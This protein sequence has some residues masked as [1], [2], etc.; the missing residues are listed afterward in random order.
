MRVKNAVVYNGNNGGGAV[1]PSAGH[2][3]PP[4]QH[5]GNNPPPSDYVVVDAVLVIGEGVGGAAVGV[6]ERKHPRITGGE[7]APQTPT[8]LEG[9]HPPFIGLFYGSRVWVLVQELTRV[10]PGVLGGLGSA[11]TTCQPWLHVRFRING[12]VMA[13][14]AWGGAWWGSGG[15]VVGDTCHTIPAIAAGA[16]TAAAAVAAGGAAHAILQRKDPIVAIGFG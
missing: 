9:A 10:V 13:W 3:D 2:L 7:V 11:F 6:S 14:G 16:T 4:E 12:V 1:G 8:R 5:T 15:Q